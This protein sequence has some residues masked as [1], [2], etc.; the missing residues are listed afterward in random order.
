[1]VMTSESKDY[2]ESGMDIKLFGY[3][4]IKETKN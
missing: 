1:M 3:K 2:E 4:L